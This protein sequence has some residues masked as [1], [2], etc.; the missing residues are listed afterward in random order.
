MAYQPGDWLTSAAFARGRNEAAEVVGRKK[1]RA[2]RQRSDSGAQNEG[3]FSD[4]D[5]REMRDSKSM[6]LGRRRYRRWVNDNTLRELAPALTASDI[7]SL[8]APPPW[9]DKSVQSPLEIVMA[10]SRDMAIWEPFRN[11][12]MDLQA[13]VLQQGL[14]RKSVG[15]VDTGRQSP[16]MKAWCG[17]ER[18]LRSA[19]RRNFASSFLQELEEKLVSFI[20]GDG[21]D[22]VLA[23]GSTYDRLLVHGSSQF[24]GL[25]SLT[26]DVPV[27]S[28]GLEVE[29][30]IL[31]RKTEK[32]HSEFNLPEFLK[33]IKQKDSAAAA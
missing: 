3:R 28:S 17:V 18:N 19:L 12:D 11:V 14:H 31:V 33:K 23:V 27:D 15:S 24:H 13:K 5:M 20:E 9:G 21:Q 32:A 22:L 25:K 6:Q 4:V 30:C 7:G 1:C 8:F 10:S 29:T 2:H 26:V 16:A